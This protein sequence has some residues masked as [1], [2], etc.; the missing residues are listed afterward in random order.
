MVTEEAPPCSHFL[1]RRPR[2]NLS[3]PRRRSAR[4]GR[5]ERGGMVEMRAG[6]V[7]LA[8]GYRSTSYRVREGE[9]PAVLLMLLLL[10]LLSVL[11][12]AAVR[13]TCIVC[14]VNHDA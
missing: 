9:P 12:V 14:G 6:A 7:R 2:A 3:P 1:R 11:A 10:L 13:R 4:R 8:A 5:R